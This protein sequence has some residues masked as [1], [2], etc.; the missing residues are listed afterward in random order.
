M[1]MIMKMKM[2][3][4]MIVIMGRIRRGGTPYNPPYRFSTVCKKSSAYLAPRTPS[5][6]LRTAKREIYMLYKKLYG[7]DS[8]ISPV[9][10]ALM[11]LSDL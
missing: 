1:I 7:T 11:K 2:I 6:L 4:I 9:K 5:P 8:S 3:M 10:Y